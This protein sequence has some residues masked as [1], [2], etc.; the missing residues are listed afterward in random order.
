MKMVRTLGLA[1]AIAMSAVLATQAIAQ[2]GPPPSPGA[3]VSVTIGGDTEISVSYSRPG[4]KDRE[5]WGALVPYKQAWRAGANNPTTFTFSSD[6]K[7]NGNSIEAG[8][9]TL[10]ITPTKDGAWTLHLQAQGEGEG[11]DE[12]EGAEDEG[13]EDVVTLQVESA[14]APEQ[15]WL[16]YGFDHLEPG[17]GPTSA[18][19][20]MHWA[21]KK[22]SFKIELD[23]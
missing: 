15:E 12:D 8:S 6:V 13:A 20:S 11:D 14:N 7:L 19:A 5:I 17:A 4:V 23:D 10:L 21:K 9:Y 2:E 3:K 16:V 18:I 22:V 1:I